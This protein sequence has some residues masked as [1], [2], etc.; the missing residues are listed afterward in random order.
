MDDSGT[1][2]F[3]IQNE[4]HEHSEE[5]SSVIKEN[6]RNEIVDED[7]ENEES[8]EQAAT[9]TQG[10]IVLE[11]VSRI[12]NNAMSTISE[13]IFG[14]RE[15]LNEVKMTVNESTSKNCNKNRFQARRSRFDKRS[16]LEQYRFDSTPQ[17]GYRYPKRPG[18][19]ASGS[20]S[21]G[22]RE[23]L[24]KMKPSQHDGVEYLNE[25]LTYFNIV[26]E[27]NGWSYQSKSLH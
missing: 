21:E 16:D 17:I 26:T 3:E 22:N 12:V 27:I 24:G 14:L 25:Y 18:L 9:Y 4:E 1:I 19:S 20:Q 13:Q 6:E 10:D 2:T 15:E 8:N 7:Q 5:G 23:R 11:S